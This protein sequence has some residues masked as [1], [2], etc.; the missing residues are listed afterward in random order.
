MHGPDGWVVVPFLH[1]HVVLPY[2]SGSVGHW[3]GVDV[4]Y[5]RV[6]VVEGKVA[7]PSASDATLL[8]SA[9]G[10]GSYGP[11]ITNGYDRS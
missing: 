4:D 8:M 11:T 9:A 10:R 3:H 7:E 6:D 5:V 2:G 1:T